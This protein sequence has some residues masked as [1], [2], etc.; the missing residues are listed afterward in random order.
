MH[1]E[2]KKEVIPGR[3]HVFFKGALPR[4]AFLLTGPAGSGKTMYCMQFLRDGIAAGE[5]CVYVSLDPLFSEEKFKRLVG[6][7]EAEVV[8]FVAP[9]TTTIAASSSSARSGKKAKDPAGAAAVLL[10]QVRG[11]V[12][13]SSGAPARVA[14]D[15]ITHLL[16]HFSESEVLE[17]VAGLASALRNAGAMA[18]VTLTTTPSRDLSDTVASLLDG[19]LQIKLE[20]EG[21]ELARSLRLL[22]VRGTYHNPVWAR[23]SITQEGSLAFGQ[24][25]QEQAELAMTICKLCDKPI[26]GKVAYDAEDAPFHPHCLETYRKL[27]DIYGSSVIHPAAIPVG[28][29]NASFFF[30]DIVGLSDP[31]LSVEKQIK[32]IENLNRLISSCDAVAKA[33]RDKRIILPTGD[34]MAIG[35]LMNPELPLQLS[36][37]LHRKLG[38]FNRGAAGAGEAIGVRIGLSA[39]PVF[40]VSDINGN[41]NVWGP[42]IILARRVM[43]IGDDRHILLADSLA[44][45]LINLKDEYRATIKLVSPKFTIKHGQAIKVYSAS[46]ADFGN[47]KVPARLAS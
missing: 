22:A 37:Q 26:A 33:P 8:L 12:A 34:G 4:G 9:T 14:V 39:G 17:F 46:G 2:E 13:A 19:T 27:S 5:R 23:F 6:S 3:R 1:D 15:S 47:P 40:V 36:M 43:D 24:D 42:G 44:E 18:V 11:S 21:K 35:F 41:Q 20:D 25:E 7:Q 28:V 32:K 31:S 16:P 10:E 45:Q 38:V 30:I 29:V